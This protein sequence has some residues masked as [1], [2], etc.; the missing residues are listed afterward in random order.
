[1]NHLSELAVRLDKTSSVTALAY[2]TGEPP[3]GAALILAHGAGASQ[4]SVFITSFARALSTLGVDT[5][6]FNFLYTEQYRRIPDRRPALESCHR[7]VVESVALE[8]E[9]TRR[10]LFTDG[11]SMGGRIAT[12]VAA[13]GCDHPISGLVLLGY[14]LHPLG[15][16]DDSRDGHLPDVSRPMLFVQGSRDSFGTPAELEPV[17]SPLT[18]SSTLHVLTGADHSFKVPKVG[19]AAQAAVY[20]DIQRTIAEWIQRIR[21]AGA[22]AV[23]G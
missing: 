18:P 15:R 23:S 2:R 1:M 7:A 19:A 17:L 5:V 12:H 9:S 13:A 20:H 21:I 4:R 22:Q 10:C 11:K 3:D 14:P 16:P 8:L 6:T